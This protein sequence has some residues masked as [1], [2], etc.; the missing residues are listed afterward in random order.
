MRASSISCAVIFLSGLISGVLSAQTLEQTMKSLLESVNRTETRVSAQILRISDNKVLYSLNDKNTLIP[1]STTK[2]VLCAALLAKLSP[3]YRMQTRFYQTGL[4]KN[5][6]VHGDLVVLGGGDPFLV[7]EELFNIATQLR[8]LGYREFTGDLVVDNSLFVEETES[9]DR[10]RGRSFSTHAYDAPISALGVNFN[11][12]VLAVSP[13][14]RVGGLAQ[15]AIEPFPLKGVHLENSIRTSKQPTK[16]YVERSTLANG[17]LRMLAT[18]NIQLGS[19]LKRIYRSGSSSGLLAGEYIASFLR[20]FGIQLRGRVKLGKRSEAATLIM[21]HD[22][23]QLS[24]LVRGLN[25]FSSNYM[26]DVLLKRLVA[27]EQHPGSFAAGVPAL[28]AFLQQ[29]GVSDPFT[30]HDGSGLNNGTRLSAD[31]LVKVLSYAANDFRI[32]PDFLASLPSGG[33]TGTLKERFQFPDAIDLRGTVR[34]KTGTLTE[35][36]VVSA[37]AGYMKHPTQG[38]LAFA[39]LQNGQERRPQAGLPNLQLSQEKALAF[40]AKNYKGTIEHGL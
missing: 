36:V 9:G 20:A 24:E 31:Q 17:E 40:F 39:I 5:G 11:T 14:D 13:S 21:S 38:L 22:S 19:E 34:A 1:A 29:V 37:L 3:S 30:L 15:V 28:S 32:F 18:G 35:P 33:E 26:A 25:Q 7:S 10:A 2:L 4:K 27:D 16:I 23:R 6:V 8:S 12:L